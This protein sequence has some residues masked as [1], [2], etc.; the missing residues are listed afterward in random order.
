MDSDGELPVVFSTRGGTRFPG[1]L[2][3][4][5]GLCFRA[6]M[7]RGGG[8]G[9]PDESPLD[10]VRFFLNTDNERIYGVAVDHGRVI[11][12]DETPTRSGSKRAFLANFRIARNLF[13]HGRVAADSPALAA[14]AIEQ[15]LARAA[16]W[17]TP[18]S[19]SGFN[20]ADFPELGP[21][22]QQD[23]LSAVQSFLAVARDVPADGPATAEQYGNAAV[24]FSKMLSILDP[25]LPMPDDARSIEAALRS[26][27]FPTWV[28]NWDYELGS[29]P[30]G[31]PAV[32]VDVFAD[33]QTVPRARLG[34]AA[35]ELTTLIR[36]EFQLEKI[37]RWPYVRLKTAAE[38]KVG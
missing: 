1:R 20:A 3:F 4:R 38:H 2:L 30:D 18:K 32:W 13:V 15:T 16:I 21:T 31:V 6:E 11:P 22:G 37:D 27:N 36:Q 9:L 5:G 17:L 23:L 29:D 28:V 7:D 12:I 8:W 25:Y 35:S 26:V 34:Q 14:A 19:V 33:D 10:G 24:A